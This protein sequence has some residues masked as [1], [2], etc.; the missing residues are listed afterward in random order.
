MDS[1]NINIMV[2]LLLE[3]IVILSIASIFL[4]LTYV[5]YVRNRNPPI[6]S[7]V[8]VTTSSINEESE[9]NTNAGDDDTTNYGEDESEDEDE[10]E[11]EYVLIDG[12]EDYLQVEDSTIPYTFPVSETQ[13]S[14]NFIT[15]YESE[16]FDDSG[17]QFSI[18]S[19]PMFEDITKYMSDI[20]E[21]NRVIKTG[22]EKCLKN[23]D[24]H[25]ME[26]GMTGVGI[27]FPSDLQPVSYS[28]LDESTLDDLLE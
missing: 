18:F 20:D 27:C 2:Q 10:D 8:N 19:D 13:D 16:T 12:N 11:V 24:G 26:Y 1:D 6:S 28:E 21:K 25:C 17:G 14:L 7:P 22:V 5:I 3:M 4:V 15:D 23:C 9:T